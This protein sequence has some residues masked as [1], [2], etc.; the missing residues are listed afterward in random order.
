MTILLANNE[1]W[2]SS[3]QTKHIKSRYFF[4]T[5]KVSKGE[6]TIEHQPT[7]KMWSDVLTK[8]KQ[9][10]GFR[11][12]RAVLMNV[13]KDYGDEKERVLTP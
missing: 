3:K 11:Q 9:G 7:E 12:D 13:G 8:L 10:T 1:G 6:L 2:S 4:V 5:D